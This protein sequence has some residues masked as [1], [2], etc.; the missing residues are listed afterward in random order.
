MVNL[1][2]ERVGKS[3]MNMM[4]RLG[5]AEIAKMSYRRQKTYI[6]ASL[7]DASLPSHG[8]EV[9]PLFS[10]AS[11]NYHWLNYKRYQPENANM[12]PQMR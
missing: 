1:E 5:V 4:L 11:S 8:S 10:W 9:F 12:L 3:P 6:R 2:P 7:E